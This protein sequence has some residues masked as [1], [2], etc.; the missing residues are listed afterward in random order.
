MALNATSLATEIRAQLLSHGFTI[1][2][3]P[4]IGNPDLIDFTEAFATAIVNHI[5]SNA[6]V[7]TT[8][9][10]PNSEHTGNIT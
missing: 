3:N 8:S 1:T 2:V 6:L 5:K 7:T 4:A 10:A 9:G